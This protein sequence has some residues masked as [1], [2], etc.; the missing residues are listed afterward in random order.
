M[1]SSLSSSYLNSQKHLT[2]STQLS[3]SGDF[4]K[5]LLSWISSYLTSCSFSVSILWPLPALRKWQDFHRALCYSF[6]FILSWGNLRLSHGW[7]DISL[8]IMILKC[9]SS[10]Q[11]TPLSARLTP[12]LEDLSHT[13]NIT[14]PKWNSW[15]MTST[16]TCI[17]L[18]NTQILKPKILLSTYP[19]TNPQL[20]VGKLLEAKKRALQ[21]D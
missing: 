2:Q 4:H 8:V 6:L 5:T 19:C 14:Y 13:L 20:H 9:I 18:L 3:F 15:L 10:A 1:D 7:N 17:Y 21:K 11:I 12:P 16:P